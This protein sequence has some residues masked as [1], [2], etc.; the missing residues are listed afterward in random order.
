MT[1]ARFKGFLELSWQTSNEESPSYSVAG[2]KAG[3]TALKTSLLSDARH[4]SFFSMHCVPANSKVCT[5]ANKR[6]LGKT[7]NNH[8]HTT[9]RKYGSW[10]V[11]EARRIQTTCSASL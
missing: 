4:E 11:S 3:E 2:E 1:E 9:L 6:V 10:P 7:S 8:Q 5:S